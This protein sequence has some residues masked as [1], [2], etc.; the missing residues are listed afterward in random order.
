MSKRANISKKILRSV[1]RSNHE[2]ELI[3]EGDR[4][5][6]G[7]SG[8]KDSMLLAHILKHMQRHAPFRFE[9]KAL[10]IHYGIDED[11]S[12]LEKQFLE[13]E[14]PY[15][16]YKTNIM[17]IIEENVRGNSSYCSF[18]ARMRRGSLYSK[19]LE[20]GFNKVALGHHLDDAIESF[21]MNMF[22]NG[23]LRSMPPIYRAYNG[24]QIIRPMI[25]LRERQIVDF[26]KDNGFEVASSCSC[27]ARMAENKKPYARDNT[28]ELL[29]DL[30][31][32]NPEIFTSLKSAFSNI[33]PSTFFSA[34]YFEK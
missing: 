27:P 18:C 10:S 6:L 4:V 28:K 17:E 32:K 21:F 34:D 2:F 24:L 33:N 3:G 26:V 31:K 22:Y 8:G 1:G 20:L 14:I 23:S 7:V 13:H 15:E 9:F 11:F 25:K 19:A 30:E 5:L 29:R 12:F 16:I